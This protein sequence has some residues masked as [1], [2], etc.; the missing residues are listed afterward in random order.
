MLAALVAA[1]LLASY[2]YL[3]PR[4]LQR[5]GPARPVQPPVARFEDNMLLAGYRLEQPAGARTVR[6]TLIWQALAPVQGDYTVFTHLLDARAVLQGQKDAKPLA[7]ARPTITWARGEVLVDVYEIPLAPAAG[8]GSYVWSGPVP[9]GEGP[10]RAP[11]APQPGATE[12]RVPVAI[13]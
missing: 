8:A 7:G 6:L 1:I 4:Y 11:V 12:V 10:A 3:A 2:P 13:R 9:A 5:R